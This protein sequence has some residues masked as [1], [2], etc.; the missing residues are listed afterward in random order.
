MFYRKSG[1]IISTKY[2]FQNIYPSLTWEFDKR[3]RAMNGEYHTLNNHSIETKVLFFGQE[4]CLPNY[5]FKGNNVRNNYVIHYIQSGKGTFSVANH[6][7]VNLKAGDIF[8]LP[9]DIPCFY[10]A[11]G[12]EP[13]SYFW[14]GFSGIKIK[15]LL[16]NSKLTKK[17][18]LRQLQTSETYESLKQLFDSLHYRSS[19]ASDVLIESLIYTFFYHLITEYP[20]ELNSK[21]KNANEELRLAVNYLEKNSANSTCTIS[22]LCNDL[23]LS[24]SYLYSIFKKNLNLSPQ[25]FLTQLRMEKAKEKLLNSNYAIQQIANI[26]GYTDAFTFSKAFKRYTGLSPKYYREKH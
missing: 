7:A 16:D 9:K 18:Y 22:A 21:A 6:H 1:I 25:A 4:N 11:D 15:G 2:I 17:Y 8:L 12:T 14:I 24:R 10:Q 5:F 26:T 3:I 13:W 20:A 23:D 19:L